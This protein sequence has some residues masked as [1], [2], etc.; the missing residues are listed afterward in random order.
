MNLHY[1][2]YLE[3]NNPLFYLGGLRAIRSSIRPLLDSDST[4]HFNKAP[5]RRC[6]LRWLLSLVL[7]V[8]MAKSH[9]KS[10]SVLPFPAKGHMTKV[11]SCKVPD[12]SKKVYIFKQWHLAGTTITKGFKEKYPQERNQTAIYQALEDG[13]KHKQLDMIFAEGC[14]GKIDSRFTP[15]FNG[16]DYTGLKAQAFQRGYDKIITLAP[17]KIEAKYGDKIEV[18][19]ADDEDLIQSGNLHLSNLRGWGG[20]YVRLSEP[21]TAE[22]LKMYSDSAADL[23]KIPHNISHAELLTQVKSRIKEELEA[24]RQSLYARNDSFVKEIQGHDFTKGAVVIGGLHVEDLREK[25]EKAGVG[26][27]IYE[28][29]GYQ[30]ENENLIQDFQRDLR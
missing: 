9:H 2:I 18:F 8:A 15:A 21:S 27:D 24:F 23:L 1:N 30:R 16:W 14:H 4:S 28:P 20:F 10:T 5:T 11:E 7:S 17:L 6:T 26:C 12:A 3:S 25:L 19:C 13:V 22:K 29:P